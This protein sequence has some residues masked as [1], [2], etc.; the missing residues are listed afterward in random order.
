ML[1]TP[2]YK[3]VYN[4]PILPCGKQAKNDPSKTSQLL[5]E[6]EQATKPKILQ[7]IWW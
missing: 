4:K 3:N 1:A 2:L 6:L 7:A 5:M